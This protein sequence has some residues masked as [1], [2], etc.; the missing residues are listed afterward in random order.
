MVSKIL[1]MGL[2]AM[3]VTGCGRE[4][5]ANLYGGPLGQTVDG[6]KNYVL[7]TNV[8]TSTDAL[9]LA[10]EH[11]AQ[12]GRSALLKSYNGFNAKFDCVD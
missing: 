7:V 6:N 1:L 4:Q 10:E 11:C 8:W 2:L 5:D 3:S 9:P 12:F